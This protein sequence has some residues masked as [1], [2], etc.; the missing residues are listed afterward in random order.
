MV[1][2]TQLIPIDEM[3]P[4]SIGAIRNAVITGLVAQASRELSLPPDRLVVRDVRPFGDLQMY[5]AGTTNST[6]ESWFYD[7]TATTP[8]AYT[9]VTGT[10]TMGDQRYVAIFGV[11]DLRGGAGL[12][13]T[14]MGTSASTLVI[15]G[16]QGDW[17]YPQLV[18]QIKINVGGSDKVIWDIQSMYAYP[19][20]T[21]FTPSAVVIP[22]NASFN[23]YYYF[24]TT[25]AGIR[26]MIQLVGVCVE[27]RGKLVSP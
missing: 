17:V 4:G 26:A 23:I 21:A 9:T 5:L 19:R 10:K 25:V 12:H 11:R 18:N 24:K 14:T 13:A 2:Q 22:Q 15:G 7:A 16:A 1:A 20:L 8:S 27:P 3:T 6:I